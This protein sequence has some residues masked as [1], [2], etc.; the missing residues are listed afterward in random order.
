[1]HPAAYFAEAVINPGGTIEK[2]WGYETPDGSSKMPS[3]ND[4][5]TVQELVDLVAFLQ[6]L[7]PPADGA[8]SHGSHGQAPS[9]HGSHTSH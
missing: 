3:F 9:G 6:S 7:R 1:M 4:S 8:T 2:G 5:M